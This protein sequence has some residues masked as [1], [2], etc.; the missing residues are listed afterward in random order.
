VGTAGTTGVGV[1]TETVGGG[2]TSGTCTTTAGTGSGGAGGA[3]TPSSARAGDAC[4]PPS[5][6]SATTTQALR[7]CHRALS[8]YEHMYPL[9]F[10]V[11][12]NFYSE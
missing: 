5:A 10:I 11:I 8:I 7:S 1:S 3:G 2:G 6:S 12:R 9:I 4:R